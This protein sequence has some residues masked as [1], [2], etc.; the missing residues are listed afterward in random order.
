MLVVQH[1]SFFRRP[2]K[3]LLIINFENLPPF[4][5]SVPE[6]SRVGCVGRSSSSSSSVRK[7]RAK[8]GVLND[9]VFFVALIGRRGGRRQ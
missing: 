5:A 2:K 9:V 3:L 7:K 1:E 4:F 6:R 8:R